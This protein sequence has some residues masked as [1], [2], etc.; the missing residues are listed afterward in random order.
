VALSLSSNRFLYLAVLIYI[1]VLSTFTILKHQAFLTSGYD[2]GIFNQAFWTTTH[3]GM[4]FYETGDLAFNPGGSFFGVHFS[5][6]LFLL[7]PFYSIWPGPEILLVM[8]SAICAI[9]AFPVFWM[10]RDKLGT[11][12][13]AV[14]AVVYLFYPALIF[15]NLN[16]FHLEAFTSTLFLFSVYY[17]EKADWPKFFVFFVLSLSTIEFAPVI[18]VFVAVYGFIL[19]AKRQLPRT[20]RALKYVILI[21][22]LSVLFLFIALESKSFFNNF[23]SPVPTTLQQ[24]PLNPTEL[25]NLISY[26]IDSKLLYIITL[27]GP[28]A[29]LPFLAPEALV[30][31][32]PWFAAAFISTYPYYHNIYYHYNGFV[33]PFIFIALIYSLKRLN[34]HQARKILQLF[35]VCSAIFGLLLTVGSEAFMDRYFP[36]PN[37]RPDAINR[38]LPLIP[39]NASILTQNDIFP[40]VSSRADAYMYLPTFT[41]VSV[42]YI[43]VDTTSGWYY[44]MPDVSGDR[45]PPKPYIEQ[46]FENGT[47]GVV[48]ST[49]GLFL[50]KK[51]Y[52]GEPIIF[53]PYSSS[54]NFETLRL[55]NGSDVKDASSASALVMN[56]G[57][58]NSGVLWFGPYIDLNPGLYK[59]TYV[60][61]VNDANPP[62]PSDFLFIVDVAHSNGQASVTKKDIFGSDISTNGE[63]LNIT[64][65][66]GLTRPVQDV[67]FR[68]IGVEGHNVSLD[69]LVVDQISPQPISKFAYSSNALFVDVGKVSDGVLVHEAGS[70]SGVFWFGPYASLPK[71][72]YTARFWLRLDKPTNSTLLDV[73]VSTDLG[74][75]LITL[76]TI[77]GSNFTEVN[78][79]Q[80]F[81]L[82]F[83]LTSDSNIVEFPGFNVRDDAPID[84]LL[85]EVYAHDKT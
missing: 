26:D 45:I 30:M 43:L 51:G 12:A 68:G 19:L 52:L 34:F 22:A 66:F 29:F 85:V 76:S 80:K 44:W 53:D 38:I 56:S 67:E 64:S 63:W 21:L 73:G 13:G 60:I 15:M 75:Q 65:I 54:F 78:D 77:Y 14:L 39:S 61:K 72:S 40:H 35:L 37:D 70:G 36:P 1:I 28:L 4:L 10:S 55:G 82:D 17:L 59:V 16:E 18:G 8:Q 42:D 49:S 81:D 5:P 48:A 57:V 25:L 71:G 47:Y 69:Y 7:V 50:L 62:K 32:L 74:K 6:F 24:F 20:K 58:D 83:T 2:L 31:A 9:G 46:V 84:L 27:F 33:I 79:W 23:T 11:R 41:D 3:D